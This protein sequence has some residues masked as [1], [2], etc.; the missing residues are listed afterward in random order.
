MKSRSLRFKLYALSAFLILLSMLIGFIGYTAETKIVKEYSYIAERNLPNIKNV[1]LMISRYRLIRSITTELGILD[2]PK[3]EGMRILDEYKEQWKSFEEAHQAYL[4]VHFAPGE[5]EIYK[6]FKKAFEDLKVSLDKAVQVYADG[7][8]TDTVDY[9]KFSEIIVKEV[10]IKGNQVAETGNALLK[11]HTDHADSRVANAQSIAKIADITLIVAILIGAALGIIFSV[12]FS[13]S[14]V[15]TLM[16]ISSALNEAGSQVSAGSTQIASTAQELSQST[17]EQ[18]ASLQETAASIEEM[19]S[20]VQKSAENAKLTNDYAAN[21]KTSAVSGQKMVQ[22]MIESVEEIDRSN[23]DI[24]QAIEESNRKMEEISQVIGEI[25]TKTKVINDIVFQ[26]KLLS[27]N[28]SVEAARA[29]EQGKG[30]A[31]VAE[32]VGNLAEM[33]GKAAREIS[34]MLDGSI[35]KVDEMIKAT[36]EK[37]DRLMHESKVKVENGTQIARKCGEVLDT[38]VTNVEDV[39]KLSSE[40]A[41]A[42]DEQAK[43]IQEISKATGMLETVTHQNSTASEES[44]RAAENLSQQAYALNK[45]VEELVVTIHGGMQEFKKAPAAKEARKEIHKNVVSI[46]EQKI[47]APTPVVKN[48]NKH[49]PKANPQKPAERVALKA[50]STDDTKKSKPVKDLGIPSKDDERFIDV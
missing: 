36:K 25:G 39:N 21:S 26:T 31:V 17:T 14:L 1:G 49:V 46:R 20:M 18:S 6:E 4:A 33:S 9:S 48:E 22:D 42:S 7:I 16:K 11:F 15:N 23:Q 19:N 47:P 45:I 37:V 34:D 5:E 30:F 35:S 41:S 43:G 50:V 8:K 28:A 10:T 3:E 12:I 32:E 29:G 27:F 24:M 2:L 13:N 44:A 40:I 38:I